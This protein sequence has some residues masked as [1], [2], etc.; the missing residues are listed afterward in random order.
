MFT[1]FFAGKTVA[2]IDVVGNQFQI[3]FTD[4]SW[5]Y[6][7][8]VGENSVLEVDYDIKSTQLDTNNKNW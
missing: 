3:W 5:I 1:N 4:D 2:R 7:E 8:S 6:L